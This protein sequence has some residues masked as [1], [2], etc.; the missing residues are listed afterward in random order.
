MIIIIMTHIKTYHIRIHIILNHISS[1][2]YI[3]YL[4]NVCLP[5]IHEKTATSNIPIDRGL[6]RAFHVVSSST[7]IPWKELET[8][9]KD[10]KEALKMSSDQGPLVICCIEGMGN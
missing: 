9:F 6:D 8:Q 1:V 7:K 5:M 10:T 4:L 2:S 3:C